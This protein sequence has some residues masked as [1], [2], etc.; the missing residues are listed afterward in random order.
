MVN[1]LQMFQEGGWVMYGIVLFGLPA[2]GLAVAHA[3]VARKW[4]LMGSAIALVLV[5]I[6]GIGG[7]IQNRIRVDEVLGS[8]A[9]N[10]EDA[11]RLRAR[12]YAE[13]YRPIQFAGIAAALGAL[14]VTV[15]EVR[16][17]TAS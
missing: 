10:R 9:I 12:G 8:V 17:K 16:R 1:L 2:L 7:T 13:S 3:L 15:G 6:L 4:S 5:L 14:L 11:E